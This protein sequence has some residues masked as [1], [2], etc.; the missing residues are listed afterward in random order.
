MAMTF[1]KDTSFPF[2][3]VARRCGVPY[4]K[5]LRIADTMKFLPV[6]HVGYWAAND[7]LIAAVVS[8]MDAEHERRKTVV[9]A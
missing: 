7:P 2:L 8:A 1:R 6:S 3:A 4:E 9:A 5:V